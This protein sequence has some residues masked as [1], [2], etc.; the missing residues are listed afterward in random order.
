MSY[1]RVLII[2]TVPYNNQTTSRALDAYFHNWEHEKIAQVFSNAKVPCK[3]HCNQLYQITDE[4]L[5]N[6][7]M[8][9][10]KEPGIIYYR[11]SLPDRWESNILEVSK[12]SKSA[13]KF[14]SKHTAT[15]HMLRHLLWRKKMWCTKQFNDWVEAFQ[16]QCVFVCSSDDFFILEIALYVAKKYNIPI[17]SAISDDYCFNRRFSLN[18]IYNWYKAS[19]MRIAKK[20]YSH[21]GNAV[22][23][24]DKIRDKYN[25]GFGLNGETVYLTSTV[26]RRKFRPINIED[27]LITYFGNIRM[28]RNNSLNDIANALGSINKKYRLEVYSNET[29][30]KIYERLKN[31]PNVFYGGTIPY[32]EV[33]K[34]MRESDITVIVEGFLPEDIDWSRYSLST[35]AADSLASGVSILTYGSLECGIISYMKSTTASMVCTNK[36]NL[37]ESIKELINNVDLQKKM[38]DQQ[39]VMTR[40]HHNLAKSCKIVENIIRKEVENG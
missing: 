29:D 10:L 36:D 23:I 20:L 15:T 3:G 5:L 14:G 12:N 22:Y 16:P 40:E 9:K 39:I 17:V 32:S 7:W 25:E 8:W 2:G 34:K 24:S 19:Y 38:Y 21:K 30:P 37:V 11:E 28:G 27:P 35:K 18:P 33:Q 13:Y 26:E 31:N 6:C 1:P 4:R